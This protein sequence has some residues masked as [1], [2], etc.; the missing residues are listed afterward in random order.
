MLANRDGSE[1]GLV[2]TFKADVE[3][4][5]GSKL[6]LDSL[7]PIADVPTIDESKS[8]FIAA[9][10]RTKPDGAVLQLVAMLRATQQAA[11]FYIDSKGTK[12]YFIPI[13]AD[14][15]LIIH[16]IYPDAFRCCLPSDQAMAALHYNKTV[17]IKSQRHLSQIFH[18]RNLNNWIKSVLIGEANTIISRGWTAWAFQ[19]AQ[20]LEGLYSTKDANYPIC[21][22]DLAVTMP[23][24]REDVMIAHLVSV[25]SKKVIDV[26]DFGCGKGGDIGKWLKCDQGI[27]RYVGVDIAKVSLEDFAERVATNAKKDKID[28]FICAD[29]GEDDLDASELL[30]YVLSESR[31]QKIVGGINRNCSCDKFDVVSCQ[32]AMHYMFQTPERADHFFSN[33]S[34]HLE[35]GGSFIA[36]TMDCRVV[37]D[38]V[39]RKQFGPIRA[40]DGSMVVLDCNGAEN[41][42]PQENRNKR[43][44]V[45]TES[46]KVVMSLDFDRENWDRLLQYDVRDDSNRNAFG[47]RYDFM[48]DDGTAG[49]EGAETAAVKAPEWLVPLGKPLED[50]ARKHDLELIFCQ[51]FQGFVQSHLRKGNV[52][53]SQYK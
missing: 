21:I 44:E 47:I 13:N 16:K 34:R 23:T 7:I 11:V 35:I 52:H 36:T 29:M 1:I 48:L 25:R 50:L 14:Q 10:K 39:Q 9:D 46:G 33:L 45:T 2:C 19:K 30:T 4:K 27:G 43:I 37:A 26:L 5:V 12:G 17:R 3:V 18:L 40:N 31:W 53:S 51:N 28:R 8:L 42:F 24:N 20:I 49:V 38:A 15:R 32:F 6:T 41:L 22:K